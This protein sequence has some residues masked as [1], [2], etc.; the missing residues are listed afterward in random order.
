M[1]FERDDGTQWANGTVTA[2]EQALL[3]PPV[4]TPPSGPREASPLNNWR[5]QGPEATWRQGQEQRTETDEDQVNMQRH[6]EL[7]AES[8]IIPLSQRRGES[9]AV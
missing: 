3:L 8:I 7:Q 5:Q 2:G 4:P 9:T 6:D 1:T